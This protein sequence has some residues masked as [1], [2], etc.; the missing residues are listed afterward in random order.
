M[1]SKLYFEGTAPETPYSRLLSL[2]VVFSVLLHL[3]AY[4]M[5]LFLFVFVFNIKF[6]MSTYMKFTI[7]ALVLMILGYPAR[8]ARVK[9]LTDTLVDYGFD[10]KSARHIAVSI[11]HNGYFT[12]YFLA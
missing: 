4:T 9:D 3:V 2:D 8:L 5:A 11:M 10:Q 7:A 6:S 12:W 1:F